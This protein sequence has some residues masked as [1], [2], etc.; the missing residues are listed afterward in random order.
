MTLQGSEHDAVLDLP[1]RI[2]IQV[3]FLFASLT[4]RLP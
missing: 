3:V 2:A 1:Y 4:T